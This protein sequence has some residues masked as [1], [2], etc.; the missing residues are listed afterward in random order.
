MSGGNGKMD[1]VE[2][3]I[4]SYQF[5]AAKSFKALQERYRKNFRYLSEE[6]LRIF[7]TKVSDILDLLRDKARRG[8]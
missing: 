4:G 1:C 3:E 5:E 2:M 6:E 7:K 8:Y